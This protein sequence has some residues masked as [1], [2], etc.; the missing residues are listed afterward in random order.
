MSNQLE[1]NRKNM[2]IFF[3]LMMKKY[4]I[5]ARMFNELLYHFSFI[6]YEDSK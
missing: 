2:N 5:Y 3:A 1:H 4:N 6:L